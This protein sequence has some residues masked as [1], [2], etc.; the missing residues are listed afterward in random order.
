MAE[1]KNV[2]TNRNYVQIIPLRR[3]VSERDIV[4]RGC[5]IRKFSE[6]EKHKLRNSEAL[7]LAWSEAEISTLDFHFVIESA[8]GNALLASDIIAALRIFKPFA[9]ST[10]PPIGLEIRNGD[11]VHVAH[12]GLFGALYDM[13]NGA[14]YTL[15]EKEIKEFEEFCK[16]FFKVIDF[17]YMRTAINRFSNAYQKGF[18]G[19]RLVDYVEE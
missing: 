17:A 9:V 1:S 6:K 8:Y 13:T 19:D 10:S 4:V 3:F 16:L 7:K 14:V 11:V 5:K 15:S 12:V 18:A 2:E